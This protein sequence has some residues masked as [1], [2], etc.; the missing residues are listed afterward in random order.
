MVSLLS[1]V[2]RQNVPQAVFDWLKENASAGIPQFN[3]TF[4]L[5][6]RK[7]GKA[8]I[9]ITG[10][11]IKT[12][13]TERQGF[14]ITNWTIDRLARVWLLLNL[15]YSDKEKYFRTIENL[16]T[17]A[18]VNELVALYSAL[19]VLKYPEIWTARCAEGIRNNIGDILQAIMCSNP[20]PSENLDDAAWNQLVLKAFFTEKPIHQIIGL[21]KRANETLAKT[22]CD[23][24]HE[25]W[26][27][28]RI[29]N[30][31]LWRCVAPFI[32]KEIFPDIEKIATSSNE[33]EQEAAALAMYHSNYAPAKE[34]INNM[35]AKDIESGKLTWS[36]LAEKTK[37]Y[38]LQ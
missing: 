32:D 13:Q 4:V 5:I 26:A 22:L 12:I 29:V 2:V 24:A 20:Y 7:T 11:Q 35:F 1:E 36:K 31:Q 28:H 19:P 9:K 8:V 23:Y 38:V 25:R 30:P 14:N 15:D 21:D 37:E 10:E 16:F 6:P 33:F 3:K 18:E 27:A 34:L 17:A